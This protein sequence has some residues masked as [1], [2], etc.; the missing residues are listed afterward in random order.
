MSKKANLRTPAFEGYT[1]STCVEGNGKS[2]YSQIRMFVF[3]SIVVTEQCII[4]GLLLKRKCFFSVAAGN[5][6]V[7][8]QLRSEHNDY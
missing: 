8:F 6:G 2:D 7:F 1:L 3:L 4:N 5:S